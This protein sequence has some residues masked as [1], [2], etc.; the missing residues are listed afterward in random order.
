MVPVE[1]SIKMAEGAERPSVSVSAGGG[2]AE[3]RLPENSDML[4]RNGKN[5]FIRNSLSVRFFCEALVHFKTAACQIFIFYCKS[6]KKHDRMEEVKR[7]R[8]F[9]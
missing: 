3:E 7:K 6:W 9:L 5:N 1:A 8:G 2:A 4:K